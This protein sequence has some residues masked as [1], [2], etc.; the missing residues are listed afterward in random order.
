MLFLTYE[1]VCG[2]NLQLICSQVFSRIYVSFGKTGLLEML[3]WRAFC[4]TR[5]LGK[6]WMS[7]SLTLQTPGTQVHSSSLDYQQCFKLVLVHF[8]VL[9]QSM[10][11]VCGTNKTPEEKRF[12][13]CTIIDNIQLMLKHK[14]ILNCSYFLGFWKQDYVQISTESEGNSPTWQEFNFKILFENLDNYKNRSNKTS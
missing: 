9:I 1:R 4:Q 6:A 7:L 12:T 8:S 5:G 2:S 10:E 3:R 11:Y 14:F 13:L